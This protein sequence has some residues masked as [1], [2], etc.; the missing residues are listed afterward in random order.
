MNGTCT[1]STHFEWQDGD[2][3]DFLLGQL[4]AIKKDPSSNK[5]ADKIHRLESKYRTYNFFDTNKDDF[6]AE[7]QSLINAIREDLPYWYGLNP[8]VLEDTLNM[9]KCC[10]I[11]GEGGIGKSYFIKCFEEE[12]EK[13]EIKHLCLYGK[14]LRGIEDIS[15]IDFEEI[16]SIGKTEE[17][18]LAFDAL[19]EI[20]HDAQLFLLEIIKDLIK[21]RGIRIVIT[22]RSHTVIASTLEKF[23]HIAETDYEFAGVS[24]ESAIEWLRTVP[25][26]DLSEYVDVLYSN[27]PLLLS[28]LQF[29]LHGD[30]AA[31]VSKNNISRYTYI[32]EQYIKR[33]TD[34]ASWRQ[35]KAIAK[36]MY[37]NNTK[38]IPVSEMAA[39]ISSHQD[40]ISKME[41]AGFI[42]LYSTKDGLY[43]SFTMDS[44][45]DYLIARHMWAEL[46]KLTPTVWAK[47]I[48]EKADAFYGIHEILILLLFD[49]FTPDYLKIKKLLIDT[50]L[51][52]YLTPETLSKVHFSSDDIC[53]FRKAF[54]PAESRNDLLLYF[55]GYVNKPFNCSNYLN[56]YYLD[57]PE[58][59]TK[60][61]TALLAKK[62]FLGMLNSRLKNA[63]YY[64]C[65]CKCPHARVI[66]T[67]YMALWASSAGNS[68]IRRLATKLL[69][70][71]IQRNPEL[72]DTSI[73]IFPKIKDHYI[74]DS[75][76]HVLSMSQSDKRINEFL[77]ILW[78]KKDFLMAKSIQ[79]ISEYLNRPYGYIALSKDHLFDSN[80]N[81]VSEDFLRF[82][83]RIDLMEKELLPFR[84]WGVKSFSSNVKFLSI[85]KQSISEFNNELAKTFSCVKTGDC[86]GI[87]GFQKKAEDYLGVSFEEKTLDGTAML[88]SM[89][90]V[91]RY[92]FAMYGL[93]FSFDSYLKQ[94]EYDFSASIF[95]KCTCIAIDIFYG[96]LMCN[97]Y[98]KEFG[99]YNNI[100]D[101]IGYEV[102]A[103]LEYGEEI[104]IR[105]PLSIYQPKP[106]KMGALVLNNL[107]FSPCKNELWWKDLRH[108]EKNAL[109]LLHPI[110]LDGH[111]WVMIAGRISVQD[112]M[113]N[114]LWKETYDLFCCTSPTVTLKDDG[115][116]R[117]LTIELDDYLGN[118]YDYT[119]NNIKPWLCKSVPTIAYDSGLFDD[120]HLILPPVE[121]INA[122]KLHLNLEEMCWKDSDE[123]PIIICNNNRSSY[124][125]DPIGG[126]VFIRKDFFDRICDSVPIKF[127]A[128]SEKYIHDKGY[129]DESAYH[130]EIIDGEIKKEIPN[131]PNRSRIPEKEIPPQ[132][133]TC[134]FNFYQPYTPGVDNPPFEFLMEYGFN[135]DQVDPAL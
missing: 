52:R 99:T 116:E 127:F 58:K 125:H 128:F 50:K 36:Y 120:S 134:K 86:C 65:K 122:L 8:V 70:E 80:A 61:L 82:L 42:T 25:V 27:N 92:A 68:D 20:P 18:V 81:T 39:L 46:D 95:R 7:I 10:L 59:Q 66:E 11:S 108:T 78:V 74:Q 19:N 91:F 56:D 93:E 54:E 43:C 109:S 97:Y 31:D 103:P 85:D 41:Q 26:I 71:V 121:L 130:F 55:A 62:R 57:N 6:L 112:K 37:E 76:I 72:I 22:Y 115:D 131:Y 21:I 34:T 28:K 3:M 64:T 119:S 16:A 123:N 88:S 1:V 106:E 83:T 29:I 87:L 48:A 114:N 84:F 133:Q 14:F 89:E 124:Y 38:E 101:S 107:D 118:L 73:S 33:L 126:T 96:S 47:T 30:P 9:H 51:I 132:C 60:E 49:K 23:Q 113:H 13:R 53:K 2:F 15:N 44:L 32:Y 24:F 117:Y 129:C 5:A 77:E 67:F 100:Q 69:F 135:E 45:A 12:L 110:K 105:S 4:P 35:T 75:L 63:I 98:T 17:F 94:D 111:E 102:Y 40:Y 79:R 104:N 90:R